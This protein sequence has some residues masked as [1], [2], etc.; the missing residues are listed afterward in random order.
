[1]VP[2]V[3][4]RLP[5][6]F[7]LP[8]LHFHHRIGAAGAGH[9]TAAH[10]A[11][12]QSSAA[13][14]LRP[15]PISVAPSLRRSRPQSHFF[16]PVDVG[17]ER[18]R[19]S[20]QPLVGFGGGPF[21]FGTLGRFMPTALIS[22]LGTWC[23]GE[24]VEDRGLKA[25]PQPGHG[26]GPTQPPSEVDSISGTTTWRLRGKPAKCLTVVLKGWIYVPCFNA[27]AS[28]ATIGTIT[29]WAMGRPG[30]FDGPKNSIFNREGMSEPVNVQRC[31]AMRSRDALRRIRQA[32]D[33]SWSRQ[34]TRSRFMGLT[35]E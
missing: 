16:S 23:A 9:R 17:A 3:F 18:G 12:P 19:M 5:M 32:S 20:V 22:Y 6:L 33:K 15:L 21:G 26:N 8:L 29:I 2:A 35:S 34:P 13:F 7:R 10:P 24:V 28:F 25:T 30:T 11:R 27:M 31:H 14:G 1:M 4:I